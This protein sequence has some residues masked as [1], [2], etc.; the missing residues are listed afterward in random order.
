[1]LI[2]RKI[3]A[4]L[5]VKLML[6]IAVL[7][8]VILAVSNLVI[9]V[10]IIPLMDQLNHR[11]GESM[12][13]LLS[14]MAEQ[15]IHRGNYEAF[16]DTL[17]GLSESNDDIAY[18]MLVDGAGKVLA[19]SDS[20]EQGKYLN[21]EI[22]LAAA[23]ATDT[24]IHEVLSDSG[25]LLFDVAVPLY[26]DGQHKGAIRVGVTANAT[27]S[28]SDTGR[29]VIVITG[30]TILI[31]GLIMAFF[32]SRRTLRPLHE[33]MDTS[34]L[35]ADGDLTRELQVK[36]DDEIGKVAASINEMIKGMRVLVSKTG[37]AA[38]SVIVA[39]KEVS[40]ASDQTAL[41]V[42]E[43][44]EGVNRIAQG[45]H[46][47]NEQAEQAT[48]SMKGLHS[49][50]EQIAEGSQEQAIHVG[51]T[52]DLVV[53]M[54]A[55]LEDVT[56]RIGEVDKL[57]INSVASAKE[58]A[59][60]VGT[61]ISSMD[62]IKES[63]YATASR[64][65][66]MGAQSEQIGEIVEVIDDIATQTNLLALNAAIEAARAGEQ[67]R[68]FAV[69]ADEIRKLAERSSRATKDIADLIYGIQEGIQS[70]IQ[71]TDRGIEEVDTGVDLAD[72]ARGALAN[73]LN[74]A[75]KT[76]SEI[77][78]ISKAVERLV[79]DS[80]DIA[81]AM[82]SV[83]AVTEESSAASEEMAAGSGE[84]NNIVESMNH[85][86]Q[87]NGALTEE[88][89]AS[90]EEIAA[91]AEQVASTTKGLVDMSDELNRIIKNFKI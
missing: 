66:E 9:F 79:A 73:I 47:Q 2:L 45:A 81:E 11:Y 76:S 50:I 43:V 84:L 90:V 24:V 68:G 59:E 41:A 82:D 77:A 53:Q 61:M 83:A 4:S 33:I 87:E 29:Q 44:A 56:G 6:M 35:V 12:G 42:S 21:D 1:M 48:S 19:H 69:V 70:A 26:I 52:S 55:S 75:E 22:G 7:I 8:V 37:E 3:G 64:I 17:K 46:D 20:T 5:Q 40:A 16:T 72:L 85:V 27:R 88:I 71:A 14:D 34:A 10:K 38:E 91:S 28:I 57:A 89:S 39:S 74:D 86:S 36:S 25:E 51:K 65:N 80:N 60:S 13:E 54:V 30:L 15:A 67:G 78:A 58:G 18:F 32:L 49:A 63:V 31:A 62:N 23:M